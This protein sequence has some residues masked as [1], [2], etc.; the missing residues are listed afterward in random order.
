[1]ASYP[2]V[3][4]PSLLLAGCVVHEAV[5]IAP[6]APASFDRSWNAALGA[7]QDVGFAITAARRSSG[8]LQAGTTR[9]VPPLPQYCKPTAASG[10]SSLQACNRR[11]GC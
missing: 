9:H 10:S 11:M 2:R 8:I 5:A 4:H 3:H 1:M 6:G 7:A